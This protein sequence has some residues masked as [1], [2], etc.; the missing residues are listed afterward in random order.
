MCGGRRLL[1]FIL[2]IGTLP[3]DADC[4]TTE[5]CDGNSQ[6]SIS[7]LNHEKAL[8]F[9][10]ADEP[11]FVATYIAD[12]ETEIITEFFL[13]ISDKDHGRQLITPYKLL[14]VLYLGV[15]T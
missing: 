14:P 7:R 2:T 6:N 5:S 11:V 3:V 15:V 1:L 9:P 12:Q 13:M 4:G 10:L 8:K